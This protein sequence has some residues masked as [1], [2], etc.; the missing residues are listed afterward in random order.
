MRRLNA[1]ILLVKEKLKDVDI[2]EG[3]VKELGFE[4]LFTSDVGSIGLTK[5]FNDGPNLIVGHY[6]QREFFIKTRATQIPIV[7]IADT[8]E[9]MIFSVST[10]HKISYLHQPFSKDIL[11]AIIDLLVVTED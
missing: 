11:S 1:K 9:R 10:S 4:V 5:N 3:M 8:D 6:S 7:L 2:I